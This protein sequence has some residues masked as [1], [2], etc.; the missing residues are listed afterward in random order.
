MFKFTQKVLDFNPSP[1][2]PDFVLTYC[3]IC[4]NGRIT[5]E[6]YRNGNKYKHLRMGEKSRL[7]HT[8]NFH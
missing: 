8:E 1:L 7:T 3:A 5:M 6:R 4:Q 2:A